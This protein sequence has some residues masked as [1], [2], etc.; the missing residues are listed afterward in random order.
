M[1]GKG[2]RRLNPKVDWV[3]RALLVVFLLLVLPALLYL[4]VAVQPS[5]W[6]MIT[7]SA[8]F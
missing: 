6:E 3:L 7:R 1:S 5:L 8:N 4:Q 2:G